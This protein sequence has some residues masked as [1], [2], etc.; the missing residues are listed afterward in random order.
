MLFFGL[1]FSV[2]PYPG[3]Y[4]ADALVYNQYDYLKEKSIDNKKCSICILAVYQRY[5]KTL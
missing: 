4:S 1:V 5:A 3:N 2:G